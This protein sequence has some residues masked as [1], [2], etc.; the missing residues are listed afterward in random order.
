MGVKYRGASVE[1]AKMRSEIPRME[2]NQQGM[3]YTFALKRGFL[4]NFCYFR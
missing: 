4:V 1:A 3:F 2:L